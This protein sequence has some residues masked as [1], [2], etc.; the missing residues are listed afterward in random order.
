LAVFDEAFLTLCGPCFKSASGWLIL[1][2][3]LSATNEA[4]VAVV[5]LAAA[6]VPRLPLALNLVELREV[7]QD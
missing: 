1:P 6:A 3:S 5:V 4:A 7:T 2:G